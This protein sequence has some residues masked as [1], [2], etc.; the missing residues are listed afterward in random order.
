M[1]VFLFALL[2]RK[3]IRWA[4]AGALWLVALV[5][6][7]TTHDGGTAAAHH[8]TDYCMSCARDA[9]GHIARSREA[10]KEFKRMTGYPHGREGYV[11]D[12]IIPLKRGGPDTPANMEWQTIEDAKAKDRIE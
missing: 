7:A 1:R 11:I 6:P 9:R 8:G 12:H 2:L 3:L 10:T 4:I 5:L